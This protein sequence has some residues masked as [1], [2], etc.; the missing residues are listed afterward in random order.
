VLD[1]ESGL[2]KRGLAEYLALVSDR[3]LP[4]VT[5]RRSALSAARRDGQSLFF[6]KHIETKLRP[7]SAA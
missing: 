3:M 1:P 4:H 7:A 6:Q 5:G 2:T